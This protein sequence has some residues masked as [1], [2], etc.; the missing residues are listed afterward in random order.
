MQLAFKC[1]IL[2]C[3]KQYN[4]FIKVYFPRIKQQVKLVK[5]KHMGF[6]KKKL[7]I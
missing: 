5:Q 6:Y 4:K 7:L 2:F 1:M 3:T